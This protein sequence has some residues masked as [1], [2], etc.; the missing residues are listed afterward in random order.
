MSSTWSSQRNSPFN[1]LRRFAGET[2]RLVER[3]ELCNV[4]LAAQ[5]EHLI[6]VAG[7]KLVCACGACGML[8]SR[9][10]L[11]EPF[12]TGAGAGAGESRRATEG[13]YRRVPRRIRYL[14][15]FQL[16]DAQWEGLLIPIE[17]AFFFRNT[18][19]DKVVAMYPSP[20]GATESL[21]SL[22]VW[23]E[24]VEGNLIL[25]EMEPDVE[26]LLV[27]R[28]R[29]GREQA[30]A[31]YFLAPIDECYSLVGLIRARWRGLSGGA[32]V[33]EEIARY[34][35]GLKARAQTVQAPADGRGPTGGAVRA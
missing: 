31:E 25:R 35:D 24:I 1:T 27:N 11:G 17:M 23:D 8:F 5:H 14:P 9:S 28:T 34:F 15:D 2:T 10:A 20:A 13:K 3:C 16:T 26:A 21:L 22:D 7:R 4:A 29:A 32:E 30:R 12:G 18:A 33:W 6:E 19:A